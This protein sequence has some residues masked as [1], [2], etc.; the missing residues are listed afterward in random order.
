MFTLGKDFRRRLE[1]AAENGEPMSASLLQLVETGEEPSKWFSGEMETEMQY[2]TDTPYRLRVM[3]IAKDIGTTHY[4]IPE[5]DSLMRDLPGYSKSDGDVTLFESYLECP[6][7][8]HID[9]GEGEDFIREAFTPANFSS[10]YMLRGTTCPKPDYH[11]NCPFLYVDMCAA[12]YTKVAPCKVIV[13]RNEVNQIMARSL[14]WDNVTMY[15]F[16]DHT[17][18]KVSLLDHICGPSDAACDFLFRAAK[19]MGIQVH[20]SCSGYHRIVK[21]NPI[22]DLEDLDHPHFVKPITLDLS[23]SGF[24]PA[25]SVFNSVAVM[26][27]SKRLCIGDHLGLNGLCPWTQLGKVVNYA[28]SPR[29]EICPICGAVH[30][31]DRTCDYC[32]HSWDADT[33]FGSFGN[34]KAW[35]L[36]EDDVW[37]FDVPE[38][39][40]RYAKMFAMCRLLS[41]QGV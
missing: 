7:R 31:C 18:T 2:R 29:M 16:K 20:A 39:S 11:Y 40:S 32:G 28:V 30:P 36:G 34:K 23:Y 19:A 13:V 33:I 3:R 24:M 6:M 35:K 12:F 22:L 27:A 26:N 21:M 14:I 15:D 4:T 10:F 37:R 5:F 17:L 9:V 38:M 25:E 41:G 8:F 1:I